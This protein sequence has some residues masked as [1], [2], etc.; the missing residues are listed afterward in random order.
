MSEQSLG[1][2]E[3]WQK[4]FVHWLGHRGFGDCSYAYCSSCGCTALLSMWNDRWPR[5]S[6]CRGQQEICPEMEADLRPCLC[7]GN[8]RQGASPQMPA[9][10]ESLSAERAA[11]DI[12][13]NAPG[14]KKGWRWQRNWTG[15]Y[16]IVIG[17][18]LMRDIFK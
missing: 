3:H 14:T 18:K 15:T 17:E 16:C 10:G 2:C 12:E 1:I 13:K 4:E 9:C 8:F 7:G 11:C 5:L 6:N